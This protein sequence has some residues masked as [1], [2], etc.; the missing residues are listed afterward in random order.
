MHV[1][2][3]TARL[4]FLVFQNGERAG[5]VHAQLRILSMSIELLKQC[6]EAPIPEDILRNAAKELGGL[7]GDH[8]D[9]L[10]LK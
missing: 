5:S 6:N 7:L 2:T 9:P 8:D 3:E 1:I 10:N 4:F